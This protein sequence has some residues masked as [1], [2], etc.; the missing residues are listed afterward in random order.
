MISNKRSTNF[1]PNSARIVATLLV[2]RQP[3]LQSAGGSNVIIAW[4]QFRV[5]ALLTLPFSLYAVGLKMP[6]QCYRGRYD[7]KWGRRAWGK[8]VRFVVLRII[9]E[10]KGSPTH[11]HQINSSGT[12]S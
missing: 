8:K 3:L 10:D 1:A 5:S 2:P 6:A 9:Q 4:P 12:V 7:V 11:V